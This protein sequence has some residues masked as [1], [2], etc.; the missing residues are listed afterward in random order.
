M[1]SPEVYLHT[2]RFRILIRLI[3]YFRAK[4]ACCISISVSQPSAELS[5]FLSSL[6]PSVNTI[7]FDLTGSTIQI[8]TYRQLQ[9]MFDEIARR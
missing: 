1:Y 7:R 6:P 4:H 9:P 8:Y 3:R 2:I 5:N